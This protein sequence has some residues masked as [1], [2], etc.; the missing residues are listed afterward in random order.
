M[1]LIDKINEDIKK[2][3]LAREK[4]KLEALRSVKA[5]LLLM[6]TEKGSEEI[7]PEK[8]IQL[9][10]KLVKQRKES[11]DI[12]IQNKRQELADKELFEARIIAVYLPAQMSVEEVEEEIKKII[13]EVGAK[14]PSDM[15]KVMG[16][17]SKQ[18]AGKADNKLVSEIVKKLLS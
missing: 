18:F 10:N 6:K 14:L 7:T 17:A 15:G 3:M 4:E 2:A 16:K 12:Y 8:E 13:A 11:A 1:S 9:L 5:A